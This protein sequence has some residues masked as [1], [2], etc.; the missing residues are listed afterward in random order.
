MHV[1]KCWTDIAPNG[2]LFRP[3]RDLY[4]R[5]RALALHCHDYVEISWIDIGR[6]RHV[7]NGMEFTVEPGSLFFIRAPDVHGLWPL[8]VETLGLT[9]IAFP[10]S[11]YEELRRRYPTE[12][13]A[14]FRDGEPFGAALMLDAAGRRTI[15]TWADELFLAP[16]HGSLPIDRFVLN[17]LTLLHKQQANAAAPAPPNAPDWLLRARRDIQQ[18]RH[19]AQGVRAFFRLAGCSREHASRELRRHFGIT[20]SQC[21]MEARMQFAARRLEMSTRSIL[22]ISLDCGFRDLAHFYK[23]FRAAHGTTPREFRMSHRIQ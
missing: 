4:R 14:A 22:D 21:V 1:L 15:N 17:L 18:P 6:A 9:N 19:F 10:S 3:V 13:A 16:R 2:E 12:M 11:V 8:G 5:R 20:P 23:A 7:L